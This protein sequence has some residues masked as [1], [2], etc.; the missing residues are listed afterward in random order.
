MSEI[1]NHA[2]VDVEVDEERRW[3]AT[4]L[5]ECGKSGRAVRTEAGENLKAKARHNHKSHARTARRREAS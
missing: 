5:C 3:L 4:W 1:L 2:L